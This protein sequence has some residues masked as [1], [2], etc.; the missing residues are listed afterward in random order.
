M[1]DESPQTADAGIA[2]VPAF[3][4]GLRPLDGR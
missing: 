4:Q 3:P 2:I 1:P